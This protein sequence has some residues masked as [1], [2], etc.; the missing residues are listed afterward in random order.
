MLKKI[1]RRNMMRRRPRAKNRSKS[2][3]F[4]LTWTMR[5]N[6]VPSVFSSKR[7]RKNAASVIPNTYTRR[8]KEPNKPPTTG[9][10]ELVADKTTTTKSTTIIA[11]H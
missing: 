5:L 7:T 4:T 9:I 6:F 11:I 2:D 3:S 8:Q 10:R 1:R